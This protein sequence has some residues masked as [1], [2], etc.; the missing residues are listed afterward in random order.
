MKKCFTLHLK[1]FNNIQFARL[2]NISPTFVYHSATDIKDTLQFHKKGSAIGHDSS[3]RKR[4]SPHISIQPYR[5]FCV[6]GLRNI[7]KG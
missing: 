6:T 7:V 2:N 5:A 4:V 1:N 3:H